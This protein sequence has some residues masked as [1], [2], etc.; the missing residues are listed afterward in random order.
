MWKITLRER[1]L[2]RTMYSSQHWKFQKSQLLI[3]FIHVTVLYL[4]CSSSNIYHLVTCIW[5]CNMLNTNCCCTYLT[6]TLFD[7]SCRSPGSN[8]WDSL[9]PSS[10]Q[11]LKNKMMLSWNKAQKKI[12]FNFS[13]FEKVILLNQ[14][15]PNSVTAHWVA[16]LARWRTKAIA[17]HIIQ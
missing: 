6:V 12:T 17:S 10:L 15:L 3:C 14:H 2:K 4:F 16:S 1:L 8:S 11:P 13:S 7:V 9:S 5:E